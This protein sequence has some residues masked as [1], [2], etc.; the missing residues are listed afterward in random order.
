M[1]ETSDTAALKDIRI[2]DLATFL[3]APFAAT[4]LA[5]F[6]AEVIKV[7]IP[8]VGDHMRRHE[9]TYKGVGYW[10]TQDNRNKKSITV[11]MHKPAG[12]EIIKQLVAISDVV[13][14]N[15]RAGTLEKWNLGYEELSRINPRIVML[16]TTTYGQTGPY[17]NRGGMAPLGEAT[18]G[19]R[20]LVGNSDGPPLPAG[21]AWG[22]YTA[23]LFGTVGILIALHDRERTG[24]GQMIDAS[25]CE[26]VFRV[27][28]YFPLAYSAEGFVPHRRGMSGAGVE[29]GGGPLLAKD[30]KWVY[31]VFPTN[32]LFSRLAQAMG[33]PGLAEDERFSNIPARHANGPALWKMIGDWV[34]ERTSK[35][36]EQVCEET[37]IPVATV[38]D[39]ADI[40]ADPY[41]T[42]RGDL[43]EWDHPVLGKVKTQGP[44]PKLSR[45][46]G[47]VKTWGPELGEH[48]KEVLGDLLGYSLKQID[49]L[50][51][52]GVV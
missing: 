37:S 34:A 45:T 43:V 50:K 10:W 3:A 8:A 35:E 42:L 26:S 7:E 28:E 40:F 11:D 4:L 5:D 23:A 38:Y 9:R 48:N 33:K 1:L 29:G 12:Q 27:L 2:L 24:L 15:F 49:Q 16:R 14:E 32:R 30:G 46:P 21:I 19:L 44:E 51:A 39:I 13:I 6:G 36:V 22:D 41:F 47:R 31:V 25:L 52:L 18:A 20:E 17:K